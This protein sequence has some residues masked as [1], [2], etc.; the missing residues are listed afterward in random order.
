MQLNKC[1]FLG[2]LGLDAKISTTKNGKPAIGLNIAVNT[3]SGDFKRTV[4][5]TVKV[6][7]KQ[8]EWLSETP[9]AKGDMVIVNSAEYRVDE[10]PDN[11]E[12]EIK[13]YHYFTVAGYGSDI[14]VIP[15]NAHAP[16]QPVANESKTDSK[17]VD[18]DPN[19]DLPF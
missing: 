15:K 8:A 16:S 4:W 5:V 3:G 17:P 6:Y 2:H 11:N 12:G 14:M 10:V 1:N 13:R 9:P 18:D 7:G 19:A